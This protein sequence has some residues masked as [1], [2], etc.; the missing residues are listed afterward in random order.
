M[1]PQENKAKG[2]PLK[3]E[4]LSGRLQH[5]LFPASSFEYLSLMF[6][7][8]FEDWLRASE[9]V[10]QKLS[11]ARPIHKLVHIPGSLSRTSVH[12]PPRGSCGD[13]GRRNAPACGPV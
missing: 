1:D 12:R 2:A 7:R 9:G 4:E 6:D 10:G 11:A 3:H 5:E 13:C 8:T